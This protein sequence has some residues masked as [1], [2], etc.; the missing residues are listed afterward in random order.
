MGTIY[1]LLARAAALRDETA[2]NS[3]S[4]ER[5]GG[6]M[7]DTIMAINELWLQ[8]GSALVISKIYTSVSAMEA[9]DEPVSDISGQPL[10]AGQIVVIASS[11]SDNGSV[12][13]FG[14][15]SEG[16]SVWAIVGLIGNITPVD[17]LD[18]DSTQL[19]LAAHQGKVLDGKISQL[20]QELARSVSVDFDLNPLLYR[21]QDYQP[22]GAVWYGLGKHRCIP[23]ESGD[24]LKIKSSKTS[25]DG[26]YAWVTNNED[27]T[28]GGN[29]PFAPGESSRHN[30]TN[31]TWVSVVAPVGSKY[32]LI[33]TVDG[34]GNSVTWET[35]LTGN[36][37]SIVFDSI[38][39]VKDKSLKILTSSVA[40]ENLASAIVDVKCWTKEEFSG[41]ATL[42]ISTFGLYNDEVM[43]SIATSNGTYLGS[44]TI[45]NSSSIPESG[46]VKYEGYSV[47]ATHNFYISITIN[48]E[49][50]NNSDCSFSGSL[51][52]II[53]MLVESYS[54]NSFY[55]KNTYIKPL[56]DDLNDAVFGGLGEYNFVVD[57]NGS[58]DYMSL[59]EC[60]DYA[61][62]LSDDTSSEK[63]PRIN[64]FI[65][66][67]T[68]NIRNYYTNEEW[69]EQG[70]VGLILPRNCRLVGIGKK[71]SDVVITC[72][73]ENSTSAI[74]T[75]NF[76]DDTYLENLTIYGEKLR[77]VIHDDFSNYIYANKYYNHREIKN[78]DFIGKS[79]AYMTIYGA[80]DTGGAVW[81]FKDCRFVN[82]TD[83][84]CFSVHD[85]NSTTGQTVADEYE[86]IDCQ[87]IGSPNG[88]TI[89][90]NIEFSP[91]LSGCANRASIVGC[92]FNSIRI[93]ADSSTLSTIDIKGH[94]NNR[95][96]QVYYYT[97]YAK[98]M[99]P[100]FSDD[101]ILG[102]NIGEDNILF[103]DYVKANN[104]N[105][106]IKSTEEDYTGIA[107]DDI[108]VG[109][110]GYIKLK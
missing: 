55:L 29:V 2:L 73:S 87:F 71:R 33:V 97:D 39:D 89:K 30:T 50:Y 36:E 83:L 38:S 94:G 109:E 12:Y 64:I 40:A 48:W 17:A 42:G 43:L 81:R 35:I 96:Y 98:S 24:I 84:A 100:K 92:N 20:G 19:P 14:G 53:F 4:P 74:S 107:L 9:D 58:G 52:K 32:L 95:D 93:I 86:L 77:Y 10:R 88:N 5:A 18:S 15:I 37:N 57:V 110:Y 28:I 27:G 65:K 47:E 11:D 62:T 1:E 61:N 102:F 70:F 90:K 46:V 85:Y 60:V 105:N 3:I 26:V 104:A 67:G 66:S 6:I 76:R 34:S 16:A 56:I 78:V 22:A 103:G 21:E 54:S 45:I 63:Q 23:V 108:A 106:L 59:R 7:Y 68:Y 99:S 31:N 49:K 72:T 25:G 79:L 82:L 41:N 69:N 51:P 101:T 44:F 75:L 80:G 91:L 8:Q 13:R